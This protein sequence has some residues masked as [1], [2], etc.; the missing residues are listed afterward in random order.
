MKL[1]RQS[2]DTTGNCAI[3]FDRDTETYKYHREKH[4]L[5]VDR[6]AGELEFIHFLTLNAISLG[7]HKLD[8][9]ATVHYLDLKQMREVNTVKLFTMTRKG[10]VVVAPFVQL[11][12]GDIAEI[13]VTEDGVQ[14]TN[15]VRH[16]L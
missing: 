16:G 9:G 3:Y 6:S 5:E 12:Q 1:R 15:D 14:E 4:R 10:F 2:F 7:T 11:H 8:D 13:E